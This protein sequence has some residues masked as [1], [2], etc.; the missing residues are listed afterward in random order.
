[1]SMIY[2]PLPDRHIRLLTVASR[3]STP[4]PNLSCT[5]RS[6]SLNDAGNYNALSYVWG[7]AASGR[8]V[9][10]NGET[11]EVTD[12]LWSALMHLQQDD[13]DAVLWIDQLCIN[14]HDPAE[15]ARQVAMMGEVYNRASTVIVWL[16]EADE[17]TDTVWGLLDE[18]EPL[19]CPGG[20][21]KVSGLT[22]SHAYVPLEPE[23]S[24]INDRASRSREMSALM[25]KDQ[26]TWDALR[27]LVSR[28]WFSRVWVFQEVVVSRHCIIRCGP[29]KLSWEAFDNAMALLEYGGFLDEFDMSVAAE[30]VTTLT[31]T[32]C[33]YADGIRTSLTH[34]LQRLRT[35]DATLQE[36]RIFAVRGLIQPACAEDLK[37]EYDEHISAT[38]AAAAK[39]CIR[40]DRSLE[41]LGSVEVRD[42]NPAATKMPCWIPD[43]RGEQSTGLIISQSTS[44][45][46]KGF[47]AGFDTLPCTLPSSS[48]RSLVLK[49]FPIARITR[50]LTVGNALNMSDPCIKMRD[51]ESER[52]KLPVWQK[53]YSDTVMALNVPNSCLRKSEH[54]D[55]Y[56]RPL[57]SDVGYTLGENIERK[58]LML[59]RVLQADMGPRAENQRT[60]GRFQMRWFPAFVAWSNRDFPS[61]PPAEVLHEHDFMA[62]IT[63][64]NRYCF[65]AED[66]DHN[67]YLGM[68]L[69]TAELGDRICILYG[70]ATPFVLRPSD[71]ALDGALSPDVTDWEF[72]AECYV[73]GI[74]D[75]EAVQNKAEDAEDTVFTMEHYYAHHER[76]AHKP[77]DF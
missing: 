39:A 68:T 10:A 42:Q 67:A 53:L 4:S 26:S 75:G 43:W 22:N 17:D 77:L 8:T 6:A 28:P 41:V 24:D 50:F 9:E 45:F 61:P 62:R 51:L 29:R 65:I 25:S 49:G 69:V 55:A 47:N 36:D 13:E 58:T 32:R 72:V 35:W 1:M 11:A 33:M 74:M 64:Y 73:D 23:E 40:H 71:H 12:N 31:S 60:S 21:R 76:M 30:D 3:S 70:G 52:W 66:D 20:I 46:K 34:L 27:N 7:Q 37:V 14:Q 18:T 15:R 5:L 54:L 19:Q 63:M 44:G 48:Q 2:A 16:G 59:S 56:T 57:W 38:Y